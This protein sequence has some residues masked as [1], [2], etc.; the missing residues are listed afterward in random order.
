MPFALYHHF[1][2]LHPQVLLRN[3]SPPRARWLRL[4]PYHP[5]TTAAWTSSAHE[6]VNQV[7]NEEVFIVSLCVDNLGPTL[8]PFH[9]KKRTSPYSS[10]GS[11]R[12]QVHG[13]LNCLGTPAVPPE[14]PKPLQIAPHQWSW[15]LALRESEVDGSPLQGVEAT[16]RFPES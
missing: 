14:F 8:R 9:L 12:L 16:W 3:S 4:T 6:S 10:A 7:E 5:E 1:R 2:S 15:C 13:H 11:R